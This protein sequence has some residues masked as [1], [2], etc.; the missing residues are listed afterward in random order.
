MLYIT[1]EKHCVIYCDVLV[2]IV[3]GSE[4]IEDGFL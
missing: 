3:V 4:H 1:V 2:N